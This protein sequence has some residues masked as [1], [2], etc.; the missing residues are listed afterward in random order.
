MPNLQ[1]LTKP[2]IHRAKWLLT[3]DAGG[4]G[5]ACISHADLLAAF[6]GRSRFLILL[7]QVYAT[8]ELARQAFF[9]STETAIT[10]TELSGA[11]VGRIDVG[12]D[13]DGHTV[14]LCSLSAA[15]SEALIELYFHGG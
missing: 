8:A 6:D 14:F 5:K 4:P 9:S 12:I 7:R 2:S 10:V 13:V 3:T 15:A 11:G 1:L